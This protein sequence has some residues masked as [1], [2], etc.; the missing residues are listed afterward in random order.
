MDPAAELADRL[1]IEAVAPMDA[2]FQQI[3]PM[4]EAAGSLEEFRA[5]VL[6]AYPKLDA[7]PL[8]RVI[9][10]AQMVA[11]ASGRAAVLTESGDR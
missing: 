9:G 4:L 8:A 3:L 6:A 7:A 10:D 2:L 1:A 5:M 11:H